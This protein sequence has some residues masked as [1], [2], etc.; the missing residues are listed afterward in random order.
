MQ[1]RTQEKKTQGEKTDKTGLISHI[2]IFPLTQD[3]TKHSYSVQSGPQI[4]PESLNNDKGI[5]GQNISNIPVTSCRKS[6][7]GHIKML[8]QLLALLKI[9]ICFSNNFPDST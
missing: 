9:S 4:S 1:K 5:T 6:L 2:S 8:L 3:A 7:Y